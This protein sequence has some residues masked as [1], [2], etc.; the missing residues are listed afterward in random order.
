MTVAWIY[1]IQNKTRTA[2]EYIIIFTFEC[3]SI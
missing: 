2:L 1:I 3:T